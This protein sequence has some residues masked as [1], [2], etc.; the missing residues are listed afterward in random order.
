MKRPC[1]IYIFYGNNINLE[2]FR[3]FQT[4]KNTAFEPFTPINA[5]SPIVVRHYWRQKLRSSY[6]WIMYNA[7]YVKKILM[8]IKRNKER[9]KK[10]EKKQTDKLKKKA[11]SLCNKP[12]RQFP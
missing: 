10:I 9:K 7:D 6:V 12:Y 1:F 11:W 3:I 8:K 5:P 2:Y 4:R